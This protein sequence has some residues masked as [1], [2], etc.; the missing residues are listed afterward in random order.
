M[1]AGLGRSLK[2]SNLS[3]LLL[4]LAQTWL[5]HQLEHVCYM[6]F[7]VLE[8]AFFRFSTILHRRRHWHRRRAMQIA[9]RFGKRYPEWSARG[10]CSVA[11]RKGSIR[12]VG[13]GVCSASDPYG[14]RNALVPIIDC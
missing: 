11:R 5:Q 12:K 1:W 8:K 6:C 14:L 10:W 3:L 9:N 2:K 7:L 13:K 4:P